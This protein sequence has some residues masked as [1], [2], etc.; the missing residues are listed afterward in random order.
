[1]IGISGDT[2][3]VGATGDESARGS[4]YV[5]ERNKGGADNWGEVRKLTASDGAVADQLGFAVG[6]SG[7]TVV[8][9]AGGDD[10]FKGSAYIYERNKGGADN[11]GEVRK[12]IASDGEG[13][14]D[15]GHSVGI[16]GDTVVAG[17]REQGGNGAAYIYERNKGGADNWGEVKRLTA[18]DGVESDLFGSWV[19]ISGDTVISGAPGEDFQKRGATYVFERNKGG[20]DNWGEVRKVTASDGVAGD[21]F[22]GSVAISVDTIVAGAPGDDSKRGSAYIFTLFPE[23]VSVSAANFQVAVLAPEMIVAVFGL[24]LATGTEVAAT[25]PLPTNLLGTKVTVKDSAGIERLAQLFFVSPGQVNYYVPAGTAIGPATVKITS[26]SGQISFGTIEIAAIAPGIFTANSTGQG[27]AAALALRVRGA[28]QTYEQISTY[29][30]GT[31]SFVPIPIDLGP[32]GD[33]VF[34][35][36]YGTGFRFRSSD[37]GVSVRVGGRT[38]QSLFSGMIGG[39]VG[40]D[41]MNISPLPRDLAGA[42]AVNIE[43]TVDGKAANVTTVSIR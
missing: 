35:V 3:V 24:D 5:F 33:Q 22:G 37:G 39:F 14:A 26:G 17:A 21:S 6:I 31:S 4:A 8:V 13:A 9:G 11:W 7:D 30:A 18:S 15:F 28:Q 32:A 41:Q 25:I 20:A 19:D 42:G 10:M 43:I 36:M 38:L 29:D 16:C 12:L 23:A 2:V 34:L 1:A 27:I 40:L